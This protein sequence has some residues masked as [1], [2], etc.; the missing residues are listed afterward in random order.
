MVALQ[1]WIKF[2]LSVD[3]LNDVQFKEFLSKL[4]DKCG[5]DAMMN[6]F[7]PL[8]DNVSRAAPKLLTTAVEIANDIIRNR[9]EIPLFLP[10]PLQ[11]ESVSAA[12]IGYI[13]AFL[14]QQ[15]HNGFSKCSRFIY[16]GCNSPNSLCVLD[17]KNIE[18][19]SL[20][21]IS[22]YTQV[23]RLRVS[24]RKI[25]DFVS[26]SNLI[27]LP[28]LTR[29]E[30]DNDERKN[31]DIDWLTNSDDNGERSLIRWEN[32]THLTLSN[33]SDDNE[34]NRRPLLPKSKFLRLLSKM[35]NLIYLKLAGVY[36]VETFNADDDST[37]SRLLP[38]LRVFVDHGTGEHI[39]D[40]IIRSC[41]HQLEMLSFSELGH[42]VS[43]DIDLRSLVEVECVS[44]VDEKIMQMIRGLPARKLKRVYFDLEEEP[45]KDAMKLVTDVLT[46]Q[47][48]LE[49]CVVAVAL[50][51]LEDCC[52]ALERG[53]FNIMDS[54]KD[55][56]ELKL[57]ITADTLFSASDIIYQ[58]SRVVNRLHDS[59]L[60]KFLFLWRFWDEDKLPNQQEWKKQIRRFAAR[61]KEKFTV[62]FGNRDIL[63]FAKY[64]KISGCI[65]N[66]I[67]DG[68][69]RSL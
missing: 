67:W 16:L 44:P 29:I 3:A 68:W 58:I 32:I 8:G 22:K 11:I 41:S 40:S 6:L 59:N 5:R 46:D 27:V 54:D 20:I 63:I 12:L 17:L 34:D 38:N 65:V 1:Q 47:K 57:V 64:S 55:C 2:R 56:I 19:Y 14:N 39:A 30:I 13:A 52:T 45:S 43:Q 62:V 48:C 60:S 33:F 69:L 25:K 4:M 24:P 18:D 35:P 42:D 36:D 9:E 26:P 51:N 7:N 61:H 66:Y 50:S 53:I 15:D 28:R 23:Y 21:P 49:Q 10:V 37:F 31:A